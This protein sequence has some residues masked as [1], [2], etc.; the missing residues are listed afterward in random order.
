MDEWQ[1]LND[2][3]IKLERELLAA[4]RDLEQQ[5][6]AAQPN[7]MLMYRVAERIDGCIAHL[8]RVNDGLACMG[9]PRS[10]A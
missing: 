9:P 10:C 4:E 3:R 7:S 6:S 5:R 2:E 8:R 1:R